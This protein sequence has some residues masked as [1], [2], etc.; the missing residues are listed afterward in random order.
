M[1]TNV[2]ISKKIMLLLAALFI[3]V[4]VFAHGVEILWYVGSILFLPSLVISLFL[5]KWIKR[6]IVISNKFARFLVLFIIEIVLLFFLI[7]IMTLI[8]FQ[9]K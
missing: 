3:P 6:C 8:F 9:L 7:I 2:L 1:K 5:L 4:I